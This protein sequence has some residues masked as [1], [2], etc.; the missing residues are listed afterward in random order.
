MRAPRLLGAAREKIIKNITS[1][2]LASPS[3][4]YSHTPHRA[5][6]TALVIYH[7][8]LWS[9]GEPFLHSV[10]GY[11]A[12]ANCIA[13]VGLASLIRRAAP[14]RL[15][16]TPHRPNTSLFINHHGT[17]D[18][19]SEAHHGNKKRVTDCG[20]SVEEPRGDSNCDQARTCGC[21]QEQH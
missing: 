14:H 21:G 3:R 2:L 7:P 20:C 18:G 9:V 6:S 19:F 5:W 17:F 10:E 8:I 12:F 15:R 4:G 13:A 16:F 1:C 11:R